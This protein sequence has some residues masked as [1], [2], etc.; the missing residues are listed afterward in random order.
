MNMEVTVYVV[1]WAPQ[2]VKERRFKGEAF[3]RWFGDGSR[4]GKRPPWAKARWVNIDGL[5]WPVIKAVALFYDLHQLALED[6]LRFSAH[7]NSKADWYSST[8]R[9]LAAR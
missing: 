4:A 2:R 1:D 6:A 7:S 5:N 3:L 8:S 9:G